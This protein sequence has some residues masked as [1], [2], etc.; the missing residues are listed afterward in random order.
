MRTAFRTKDEA[1]AYAMQLRDAR[2][3]PDT[4]VIWASDPIHHAIGRVNIVRC[5]AF[6]PKG[7]RVAAF[8]ISFTS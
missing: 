8:T 2:R 4:N 1:E 3:D 5:V 7:K 6:T